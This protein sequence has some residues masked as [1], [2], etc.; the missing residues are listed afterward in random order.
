MHCDGHKARGKKKGDR[1]ADGRVE[2]GR[3][4]Q[5]LAFEGE[6]REKKIEKIRKR[7]NVFA[8]QSA[9]PVT[10]AAYYAIGFRNESPQKPIY[11]WTSDKQYCLP[12]C[13]QLKKKV[14]LGFKK[15]LV[16]K[17]TEA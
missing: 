15:K 5:P 11:R 16:L 14:Y 17:A 7:G 12:T 9:N 4:A 8:L 1:S 10:R 13:L 2:G 3:P 6:I